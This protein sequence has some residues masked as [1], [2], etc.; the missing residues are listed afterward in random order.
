MIRK[1]VSI[2][3][4]VLIIGMIGKVGAEE[5]KKDIPISI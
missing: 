2:C 5:A 1:Y 4:M 3:A